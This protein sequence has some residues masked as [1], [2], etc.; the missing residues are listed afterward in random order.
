M[1]L[2]NFKAIGQAWT[3]LHASK[4][5]KLDAC[6]WSL[7]ANLV[8]FISSGGEFWYY[9]RITINKQNHLIDHDQYDTSAL[10]HH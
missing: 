6:I 1:Y 2:Q 10:V 4:V 8:T 7:F 5:E 3:K 9:N